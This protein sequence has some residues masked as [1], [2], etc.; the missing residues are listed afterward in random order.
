MLALLC[1]VVAFGIYGQAAESH[2]LDTRVATLTQQ[3]AAL[4]QAIS[5]RQREIVE[6][7]TAAWLVEEARKLGYVFPGEKVF[8]I[9]PS[10]GAPPSG[11]V[12]APLP[13]FSP[14]PSPT[15]T[16]TATPSSPHPIIIG[17]P[18]PSPTPTPH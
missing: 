7:Q 4:Q 18:S 1:G 11:G 17:S 16:P 13:S 14:T 9:T 3:N 2:A 8:V 10:G 5:D 6:A 12:N 15:P